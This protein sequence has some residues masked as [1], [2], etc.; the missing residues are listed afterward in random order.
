MAVAGMMRLETLGCRTR[1]QPLVVAATL[2]LVAC[3]GR[4][5]SRQGSEGGGGSSTAGTAATSGGLD[6]QPTA[7]TAA[8][9]GTATAAPQSPNSVS[10]I[11][12]G[13]AAVDRAA[14]ADTS[15]G[16]C[17]V[18]F[19][20]VLNGMRVGLVAFVQEP[21]DYTGDSLHV[22]FAQAT[23]AE[24]RS[25]V[26]SAGTMFEGAIALHVS[27]VV[28]RFVGTAE[29]LLLNE[30]QPE[31]DPLELTLAFDVSWERACGD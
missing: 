28:P 14:T 22:L 27:S 30:A 5:S 23:T 11:G 20:A 17:F 3:G 15:L 2:V 21:G 13:D 26:A 19:T 18:G 8:T 16:R 24:G 12:G 9:A 7:G 29:L 4:A 10:L 25:Y 6:A 1:W 31:A